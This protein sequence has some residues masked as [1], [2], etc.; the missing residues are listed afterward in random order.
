MVTTPRKGLPEFWVTSL[1]KALSG[2]QP[3]VLSTWMQGYFKL[4]KGAA[5]QASM[6]VW[7]ANHSAQLAD[8]VE[9]FRADG[10]KCSVERYFRVQ[11]QTAI[12]TGKSDLIIQQTDKRPR[13]C[14]VKS[15]SPRD[16][17]LIQ[18]LVEMIAIPMSWESPHMQF[19]GEVIYADHSVLLKPDD[20][21]ALRP[22]LFELLKKLG[23]IP[24]PDASPSESAC[25]FCPVQVADCPDRM[26]QTPE[27]AVVHTSLF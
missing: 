24:R 12:I 6:S 26:G 11:G 8:A 9:K 21:L 4:A 10:W 13:I 23:S 25:R 2:D 20:A 3:C 15:G 1:A 27:T 7:R 18:V 19:D 5:D 16:S 17:D 22:R 14:D